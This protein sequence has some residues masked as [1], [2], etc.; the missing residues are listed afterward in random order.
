MFWSFIPLRASSH[1]DRCEKHL[2]GSWEGGVGAQIGCEIC[3]KTGI[4]HQTYALGLHI[5]EGLRRTSPGRGNPTRLQAFEG[6]DEDRVFLVCRIRF[7]S[8]LD[9]LGVS[10][11]MLVAPRFEPAKSGVLPYFFPVAANFRKW[12]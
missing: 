1:G 3:P 9:S 2:D 12:K 11:A 4:F 6:V 5:R 7:H 8:V 10:I